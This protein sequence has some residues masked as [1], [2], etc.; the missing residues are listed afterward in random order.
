MLSRR[1]ARGQVAVI[2]TVILA[3][4][5]GA[6]SLGADVA[7]RYYNW[8][9]LQKAA[10]AA[11]L[12]GANYLPYDPA[13]ATTTA[14]SYATQNGLAQSEIVSTTVS[15]DGLSITMLV[16]RSVPYFFA[17]VLGL[18]NA[19]VKAAATAGIQTNAQGARGL[20]PMGL[21]CN[22]GN[23]SYKT[24]QKYQLKQGQQGPGNWSALALGQSGAATYRTNMELGYIGSI[25]QT[26]T[27]ETG[28]V[29][30]PTRQAIN[31]RLNLAQ[32]ADP[33]G[34]WQNPSQYD[35]RL[36]VVP[37]VDFTNA[38]GNS[39]LPVVSYALMWIDSISNNNATINAYFLSTIPANQIDSSTN[40]CGILGPIL[41]Q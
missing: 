4:L 2:T 5:I 14:Q 26:V 29:V 22:S 34:S 9:Q 23:C 10:D 38:Q 25:S 32:T 30:G 39:S 7:L 31:T 15:P 19:P 16:S 17:R 28:N 20:I 27:T 1:Y 24:G 21:A 33:S 41:K 37:M 3:T 8:E 36:V 13:D 18:T 12:A 6:V 11:V 40:D 35:P